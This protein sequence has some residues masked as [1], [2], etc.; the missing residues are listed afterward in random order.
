M[1]HATTISNEQNLFIIF[2]SL[3]G[4]K[5][6]VTV[7]SSSV[8]AGDRMTISIMIFQA[9]LMKKTAQFFPEAAKNT[10]T[11]ANWRSVLQFRG[12]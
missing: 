10:P 6:T 3:L 8:P 5:R 7:T 9:R 1:L 12:A 11:D 2:A 4:L